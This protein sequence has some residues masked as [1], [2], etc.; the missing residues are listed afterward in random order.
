MTVSFFLKSVLVS[1][2][3]AMSDEETKK[4]GTSDAEDE[5]EKPIL[6]GQRK[7]NIL[8]KFNIC[9]KSDED[10]EVVC[11]K[12]TKTFLINISFL[13]IVK[14]SKS[15]QMQKSNA[16]NISQGICESIRGPT[17]LDLQEIYHTDLD[18]ISFLFLVECAGSL[19]GSFASETH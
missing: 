2:K 18:T 9:E 16:S 6:G 14:K 7:K 4:S 3:E 17:L 5:E 15:L 13:A 19:I 12:L 10:V 11:D 1:S 8:Q